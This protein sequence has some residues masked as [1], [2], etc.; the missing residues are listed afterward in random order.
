MVNCSYRKRG[1]RAVQPDVSYYIGSRVTLAPTQSSIVDLD[2]N[3]PPD[4][5]IEIADTS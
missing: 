4:L 1:M 2:N 3:Q 5:V